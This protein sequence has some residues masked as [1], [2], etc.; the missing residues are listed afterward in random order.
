MMR[1]LVFRYTK[2]LLILL[3]VTL[4]S[5]VFI[6]RVPA[7]V[8]SNFSMSVDIG[9]DS[10]CK[11]NHWT[12]VRA[13][14]E[15][16]GPDT[17]GQIE[18]HLISF[19]GQRTVYASFVELP[20]LSRKELSL[21]VYPDGHRAE[22]EVF[23]IVNGQQA[24][25]QTVLLN[26]SPTNDLLIGLWAA[27]PT[28]FYSLSD[29]AQA[30]RVPALIPIDSQHIPE[31]A[32]AMSAL[33]ILVIAGVD[34]GELN[35]AQ[36]ASLQ[37]W[38][39]Q[40]GRLVVS[41]GTHWQMTAAGIGD[42]LP[43]QP[44]RSVTLPDLN[45]LEDLTPQPSRSGALEVPAV[46]AAGTLVESA[47]VIVS[48]GDRDQGNLPLVVQNRIG[49]GS[50]YYLAADPSLA[51]WNGWDGSPAFFRNLLGR[52]LDL[53]SWNSGLG[54]G[55]SANLAASRIPVLDLPSGF[56]ICGFLGLYVLT[57]GPMNYY[58]L[59]KLKRRELAWIS[60]PALV[61]VF[62]VLS[63]L[64]GNFMRGG[65]PVLNKLSII[66]VR[67]G[68]SEAQVDGIVGVFSPARGTY[69]LKAG[70]SYLLHPLSESQSQREWML[71]QAHDGTIIP[72]LRIEGGSVSVFGM[73]GRT[74]SPVFSHTLTL[75]NGAS[76]SRSLLLTG[77][78]T[79]QSSLTLRNALL[80]A[81]GGSQALGDL[82]PGETRQISLQLTQAQQGNISNVNTQ[83]S[84]ANPVPQFYGYEDPT[85]IEITGS[86]AYYED[87]QAYTRYHLLKAASPSGSNRGG[88]VYL[89]GWTD[90]SPLQIGFEENTAGR[91]TIEATSLYLIS[92]P[93]TFDLGDEQI[94]LPPAAFSWA[95]LESNSYTSITPYDL[96]GITGGISLEF[97]LAQ[98][99][100]FGHVESL[101]F[102]LD[103][104]ASSTAPQFEA[105]LWD[106]QSQDWEQ[107]G[108]LKWG[109]NDIPNPARFIGTGSRIQLKIDPGNAGN[110]PIRA[111]DFT[112]VVEP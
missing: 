44:V 3:I 76:G 80:L 5:V 62:S 95:L 83:N 46:V 18:A 74:Q 48:Y 61:I 53:P 90:E 112:L 40:G 4:A 57:A 67:P 98:P 66:Q 75:K 71:V 19:S 15:N 87:P 21:Y 7:Q 13:I 20:G 104:L 60:V 23:F 37:E 99:I 31:R 8:S 63:I 28:A 89:S 77:S 91:Y 36:R 29:L 97:W 94:V 59:R 43:I 81:P 69:N 9:F 79:N 86:S 52:P 6:Y 73:S 96:Y 14:L 26:C 11:E 1:H 110:A 101:I 102:H 45:A 39:E 84:A 34:T 35:Q 100:S 41:G 12:Q 78:V 108:E 38:L 72:D 93:P 109:D 55:Y 54:D 105:Y 49:A 32:E 70:S 106:F 47:Q 17:S 58:V 22:V 64:V 68:A 27:S 85:L 25:A 16:N 24:A 65:Q 111:L 50:V 92:L 103:P 88:G 33:D 82:G 42:L 51:P 107:I 2:S 56:L 30:S 10:R